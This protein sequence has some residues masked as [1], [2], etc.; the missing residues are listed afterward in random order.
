MG[1][2]DLGEFGDENPMEIPDEGGDN[3]LDFGGEDEEDDGS[4]CMQCFDPCGCFGKEFIG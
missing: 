3:G 2:G 1:G 4:S